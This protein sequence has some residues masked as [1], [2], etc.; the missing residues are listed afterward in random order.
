MFG[1]QRL[2]FEVQVLEKK[3]LRLR[4]LADGSQ[5]RCQI[6][7]S[8]DQLRI[9]PRQS[10]LLKLKCRLKQIVSVLE[11]P[12][13][14]TGLTQIVVR[15]SHDR[16][17]RIQQFPPYCERLSQHFFGSSILSASGSD[18][19]QPIQNVSMLQALGRCVSHRSIAHR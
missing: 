18:E 17:C 6:V 5:Q 11:L 15:D 14:K 10:R 19:R 7:P 13:P 4:M 2:P 16:I 12:M 1:P 8:A 3:P 9:V